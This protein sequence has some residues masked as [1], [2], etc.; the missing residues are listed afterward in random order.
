MVT[1]FLHRLFEP[2]PSETPF[3]QPYERH[4]T[5]I[6][7]TRSA[8]NL[9]RYN[10]HG[11]RWYK[12]TV[13]TS[14]GKIELRIADDQEVFDAAEPVALEIENEIETFLLRFQQYLKTESKFRPAQREEILRKTIESIT[15][16]NKTNPD[17][18]DIYFKEHFGSEL[19]GCTYI[20]GEF[21]NL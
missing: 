15:F 2:S 14:A 20:N 10:E 16:L 12:K 7:T 5:L 6:E 9:V 11:E 4:F 8:F 1:K 19:W 21:K 17:I 3:F 18:A 13:D